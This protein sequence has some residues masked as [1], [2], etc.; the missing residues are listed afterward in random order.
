MHTSVESMRIYFTEKIA[1]LQKTI[2]DVSMKDDH[3]N[4]IIKENEVLR[5]ENAMVNLR[6]QNLEYR[7]LALE[8]K[9]E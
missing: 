3:F 7:L 9:L 1:S 6:C 5:R 8:K 2:N 4:Q